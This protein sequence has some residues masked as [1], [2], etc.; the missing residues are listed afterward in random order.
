MA[1]VEFMSLL[2]KGDGMGV[3]SVGQGVARLGRGSGG[4]EGQGWH[5]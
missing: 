3:A 4:V 2:G 5:S 1:D